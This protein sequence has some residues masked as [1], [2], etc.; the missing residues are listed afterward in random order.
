MTEN[1]IS[2]DILNAAVR[3]HKALGPGLLESIY[4]EVLSHELKK[5]GIQFQRQHPIP[6][7]YEGIQLGSA[8]RADLIV[9]DKVIIEI[10]AVEAILAIHRTQLL[11]YLRLTKKRLGILLNFNTVLIKDGMRRVVNDL[12]ETEQP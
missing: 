9:E 10:K 11:S 5:K 2:A 1:E 4:E 7:V 3:T 12:P 6:I 8:F